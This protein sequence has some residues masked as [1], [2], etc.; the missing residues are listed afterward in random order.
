MTLR[1]GVLV[2]LLA[3]SAAPATAEIYRQVDAQGNVTYSDEPSSGAETIEV[4]PV[5]TITLPKL[6]AIATPSPDTPAAPERESYQRLR[7]VAPGNNDAFH[8]GSGDV[9][10]RVSSAPALKQG[11]K[12]EITL[13][14]QPVGQSHS[15]SVMV[16]NVYR[17]T[18]TAQVHIVDENGIR[19][20][21]G[22]SVTFTIHRPSV[23]N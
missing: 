17:G 16:R 3:F 4:R 2:G 9:E 14:G 20:K 5:T 22:D 1:L 10:F 13:D 6:E 15:G 23:L 7:F 8:S 12:F 18:H 11:H 21:T 19:V